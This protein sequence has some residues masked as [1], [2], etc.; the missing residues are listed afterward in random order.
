MATVCIPMGMPFECSGAPNFSSYS[1]DATNTQVEW[2]FQADEPATITKLGFAMLSKTGTPPSY[3]ISL[4][5]VD[6]S[7]N[8]DG[9]IKGGGS[10]V[11]HTFTPPNDTTWNNTWQWI[12]LDNSYTCTNG[13]PLAIVIAYASGTINS[14]NKITVN[15]L[16]GASAALDLPYVIQNTTGS[17]TRQSNPPVFGYASSTRAYGRPM[18]ALTATNVNSGTSPNEFAIAFQLPTTLCTTYKVG[19]VRWLAGRPAGTSL[20]VQLYSGTTVLQS[21]AALDS[22][23]VLTAGSVHLGKVV[24]QDSSLTTLNAGTTYRIGFAP[25]NTSNWSMQDM[26]VS[27]A[28]DFDA[29][30]GQQKFWKSTRTG[31]GS[32]SDDTTK[33]MFA[34]IILYDVAIPASLGVLNSPIVQ[35]FPARRK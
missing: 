30:P 7:G 34:E 2:I 16:H 12:T 9:T 13:E 10:P 21:T 4:Q 11:S 5:G 26:T 8:P 29:Y 20:Q 28:S 17:R 6:G 33:R 14:S 23:L 31:A 19:A 3:T 27:A 32:W 35:G 1:L 25:A 15:H 24:F 18:K 22:D